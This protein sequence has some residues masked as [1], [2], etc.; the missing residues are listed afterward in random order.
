MAENKSKVVCSSS[1]PIDLSDGRTLAPGESAEDV[2]TTHPHQ[3][4]LVLDGHIVVLEGT[5]P[6]VRVPADQTTD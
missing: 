1:H 6:R 2:D 4:A 3:R 5:T